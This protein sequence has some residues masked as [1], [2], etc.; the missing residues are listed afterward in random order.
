MMM[1]RGNT[2]LVSAKVHLE[3][4]GFAPFPLAFYLF[5]PVYRSEICMNASNYNFWPSVQ[6]SGDF[7]GYF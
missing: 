4:R 3:L 1:F 2:N 5:F 7:I 6:S